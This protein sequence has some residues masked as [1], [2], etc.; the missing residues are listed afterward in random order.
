[1][2]TKFRKPLTTLLSQHNQP[3][4]DK[5]RAQL[6]EEWAERTLDSLLA[7]IK[8]ESSFGNKFC[9]KVEFDDELAQQMLRHLKAARKG[10]PKGPKRWTRKRYL[11]MLMNYQIR[12]ALCGREDALEWTG[13]NE[14]IGVHGKDGFNP[15]KVEDKITKARKVISDDKLAPYLPDFVR[16]P[17]NRTN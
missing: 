5:E 12:K 9:K 4:S 2:V 3:L 7:Y 10:K 16:N 15:K 17:P 6:G 13:E 8:T 11:G 1:M 14:G